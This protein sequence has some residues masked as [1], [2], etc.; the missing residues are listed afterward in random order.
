MP[1]GNVEV[2]RRLVEA[3][4]R[5]DVEGVLATFD[6][7][8]RLD[9]P[10]EMPDTPAEGFRGHDGIRRWMANLRG[11]AG[12]R[13]EPKGFRTKGEV[14]LAEWLASGVGEGSGV[15]FEWATYA[16][17]HVR[18]GKVVRAQAFLDEEQAHDAAG[19]DL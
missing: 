19:L 17:L 9:E 3:F 11:T 12:I 2:V 5:D 16:V 7:N 8:C 18:A 13:F 1:E 14:V 10:P 15:P 4:N 6:E